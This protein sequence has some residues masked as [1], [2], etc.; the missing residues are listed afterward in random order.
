MVFDPTPPPSDDEFKVLRG[1]QIAPHTLGETMR[2]FQD[3]VPLAVPSQ[4]ELM[5]ESME[6]NDKAAHEAKM[7]EQEYKIKS[8]LVAAGV[9]GAGL[10]M[11]GLNA[12]PENSLGNQSPALTVP[13]DGLQSKQQAAAPITDKNALP[14]TVAKGT[15]SQDSSIT[16]DQCY[17]EGMNRLENQWRVDSEKLAATKGTAASHVGRLQ[18]QFDKDAANLGSNCWKR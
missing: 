10:V 3:F 15:Q 16:P 8:R 18:A 1:P 6:K 11:S 2:S 13:L 4:A 7:L 17:E 9:L 12:K 5:R 14:K